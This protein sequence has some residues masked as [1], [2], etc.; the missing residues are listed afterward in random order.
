[1]KKAGQ[2]TKGAGR[3]AAGWLRFAA[4]PPSPFIRKEGFQGAWD[5]RVPRNPASPD[6]LQD[7]LQRLGARRVEATLVAILA[8]HGPAGTREIVAR[9]G[10]RQPEVS[11][12]MQ[13]L[14]DRGWVK[15]EA[16]PR[17]GKGRP[18][19]RYRLAVPPPQVRRHYEGEG[20]RRLDEVDAALQA[21]RKA[22]G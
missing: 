6:G 2:G 12:G 15:A 17:V 8:T 10:L 18:M 13:A 1:M 5:E 16:V 4:L 19:H 7:A 21:V 22:L 9:T 14:R 20:R 11:V 3:G